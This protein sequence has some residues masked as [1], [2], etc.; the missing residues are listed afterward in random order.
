MNNNAKTICIIG[1]DHFRKNLL[2][3]N[4]FKYVKENKIIVGLFKNH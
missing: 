2:S 4:N 1:Y 3:G